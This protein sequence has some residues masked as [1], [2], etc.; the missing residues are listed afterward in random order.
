MM[1]TSTDWPD[2]TLSGPEIRQAAMNAIE[3]RIRAITQGRRDRYGYQGPGWDPQI[4]GRLAEQAWAKLSGSYLADRDDLDY[5]GDVGRGIQIRSTRH[6]P[7][8]LRVNEADVD[9]H[10]FILA[11][12]QGP[13]W[14]FPGWCY[15]REAKQREFWRDE[16]NGV[17]LRAGGFYI[18][19]EDLHPIP[20]ERLAP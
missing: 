15:A 6:Q 2:V 9:G 16:V 10:V 3:S 14:A 8:L 13:R 17:K 4:E 1:A 11:V 12:G 19:V 5:D 20:L 18:G 7:P